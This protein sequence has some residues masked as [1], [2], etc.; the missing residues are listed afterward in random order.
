MYV[1][2]CGEMLRILS[3]TMY[4]SKTNGAIRFSSHP[5]GS[6][7]Y[8]LF[9]SLLEMFLFFLFCFLGLHMQHIEV[10]RLGVESE[11][12]LLVYTTA[13]TTRDLSHICNLCHSLQQCLI[14]NILSEARDPGS[15]PHGN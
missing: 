7:K 4:C 10:P 14:L 1:C 12:Q 13:R 5:G 9:C 8:K 2:V 3:F 6:L 15:N 11:L